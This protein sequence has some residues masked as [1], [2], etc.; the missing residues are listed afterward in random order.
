MYLP[1]VVIPIKFY[2]H[3][4]FSLQVHSHLI[5]FLEC[6]DQMVEVFFSEIL[7]AEV[8]RHQDE[9]EVSSFMPP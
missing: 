1:F 5:I 7:D 3:I 9:A 6:L 4:F 8:I 2:F